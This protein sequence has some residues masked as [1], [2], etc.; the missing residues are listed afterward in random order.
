MVNPKPSS[1]TELLGAV[2]DE[3]GILSM[4]FS[5]TAAQNLLSVLAWQGV[6]RVEKNLQNHTISVNMCLVRVLTK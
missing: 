6:L 5:V 2:V 3:L 4:K 1:V